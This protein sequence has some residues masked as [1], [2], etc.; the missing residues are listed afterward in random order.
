MQ[1]A[2]VSRVYLNGFWFFLCFACSF[3][4]FLASFFASFFAF[5]FPFATFFAAFFG[6]FFFMPVLE[7]TDESRLTGKGE[8]DGERHTERSS[9]S[10]LEPALPR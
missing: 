9:G 7:R 8:R 3:A 4:S 10:G 2:F 1:L 5:F 6:A